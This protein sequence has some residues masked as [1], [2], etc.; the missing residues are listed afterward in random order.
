MGPTGFFAVS[1]RYESLDT[2]ADPL[3]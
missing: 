1:E 2:K 3:L